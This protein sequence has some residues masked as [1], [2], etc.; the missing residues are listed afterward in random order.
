MKINKDYMM[1]MRAGK[2]QLQRGYLAN[3]EKEDK[4]L[5]AVILAGVIGLIALIVAV[6]M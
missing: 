1:V 4:A 5:H 2:L 3:K 6:L